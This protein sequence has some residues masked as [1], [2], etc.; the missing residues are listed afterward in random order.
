AGLRSTCYRG[1]APGP[2]PK[3]PVVKRT[4]VVEPK[5]S[6]DD[7]LPPIY[8]RDYAV[9]RDAPIV[10]DSICRKNFDLGAYTIVKR[11]GHTCEMSE[12]I[13]LGDA[14]IELQLTIVSASPN[15]DAGLKF[16][17]SAD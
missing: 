1:S 2:T 15:T 16:G 8:D 4:I 10:S 3:K 6:P 5:I 9:V 7:T 12:M 11:P 14:R 17:M 13:N